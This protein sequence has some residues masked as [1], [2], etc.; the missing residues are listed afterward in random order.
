MSLSGLCMVC[1]CAT[2]GQKAVQ[3]P[4]TG[5]AGP[6]EL[7]EVRARTQIYI[8]GKS[9]KDTYPLSHLTCHAKF[10]LK[11]L[12]CIIHLNFP[13][14]SH[15]FKYFL[16]DFIPGVSITSLLSPTPHRSIPPTLPSQLLFSFLSILRVRC[17]Q[18][19]YSQM[20][21]L[22]FVH[23]QHISGYTVKEM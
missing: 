6:C 9:N 11:L 21:G 3:M 12:K 16:G 10:T 23:S 19:I 8:L 15:S 14:E 4:G 7:S 17:V 18:S 1:E 20:C 22:P 13:A 2:G 5:V